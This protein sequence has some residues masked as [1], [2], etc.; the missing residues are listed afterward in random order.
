LNKKVLG[1]AVIVLALGMLTMSVSSALAKKPT[2]MTLSGYVLVIGAGT[3]TDFPAGKSD[4][5]QI[6]FRDVPFILGGDIMAGVYIDQNTW[7]I[8]GLYHAN[9][10]LK[11]SG[12]RTWTGTWTMESATVAGIGSGSLTFGS[13]WDEDEPVATWWIT[14]ATGDLSGLKGRGT[15]WEIAG[16]YLFGYEFEVQIP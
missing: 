1:I 16:P 2:T 5:Y 11:L 12:D 8:G 10:L 13:S 15:A 14:K 3:G 4:N 9:E 7:S 6:K